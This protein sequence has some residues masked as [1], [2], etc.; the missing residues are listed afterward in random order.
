MTGMT[1]HRHVVDAE[2]H[3]DS[4]QCRCVIC[5]AVWCVLCHSEIVETDET[6]NFPLC[7]P[8]GGHDQLAGAPT[9]LW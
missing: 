6:S 2:S 8:C 9:P 4:A 1:S 7:V 5:G 3:A